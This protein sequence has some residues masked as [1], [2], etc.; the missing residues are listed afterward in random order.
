[1]KNCFLFFLSVL[2]VQ[3][4]AKERSGPWWQFF[5]WVQSVF[6]IGSSQ[7]KRGL[8]SLWVPDRDM[9]CG[10]PGLQ[11][12]R[13]FLLIGGEENKRGWAPG[14]RRM[15]AD[16]STMALQWREHWN[17]KLRGFR[18]QDSKG[19]CPSNTNSTT[20]TH[21]HLQTREEYIPPHLEQHEWQPMSVSDHTHSRSKASNSHKDS[22]N[23]QNKQ[24]HHSHDRDIFESEDAQRELQET[25][26]PSSDL[27]A[28][29]SPLPT[30]LQPTILPMSYS[31]T[32]EIK[33]EKIIE[34]EIKH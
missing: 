31:V 28:N 6:R 11:V 29:T 24:R 8:Q 21:Y 25:Q 16:R 10:C 17:A 12:G 3:V 13:T 15:I 9:S 26:P 32:H 14:E 20:R 5:V 7:V 1:M 30:E 27:P 22:T 18:S 2:K 4:R 34:I 19:K 23:V 33:Q